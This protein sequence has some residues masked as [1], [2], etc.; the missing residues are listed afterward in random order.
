MS[1]RIRA[2]V[3]AAAYAFVSG[4]KV[5]GVHDHESGR[6]LLIAAEARG[7]RLQGFDGDKSSKFI[8]TSSEL[9]D[10]GDDAYVSLQIDGSK[11]RGYDRLSSSHYS[12]IV[13]GQVV[14]LYDYA[15]SEWF[16]FSIQ[17]A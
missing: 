12:L 14:Q 7:T 16:D 9:Y 15:A 1:P 5:A 17:V 10:A 8:G 6:D 2:I 3:A 13:E 11:A 4:K